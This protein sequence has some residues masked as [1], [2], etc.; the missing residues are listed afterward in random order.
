MT[1]SNLPQSDSENDIFYEAEEPEETDLSPQQKKSVALEHN[2]DMTAASGEGTETCH[3]KLSSCRSHLF[4]LEE[5]SQE[6]NFSHTSQEAGCAPQPVTAGERL[7][8]GLMKDCGKNLLEVT[9]AL[10]KTS[11][12][13]TLAQCHLLQGTLSKPLWSQ[14]EDQLLLSADPISKCQ[15]E[16]RYGKESV[17]A[18]FSFLQA[19]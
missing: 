2:G 11:G 16:K 10:L 17:S 13:L 14:K 7:V 9:K 8:L 4:L 6:D 1:A 19:E 15:L 18:R 3:V 12:D 5:E